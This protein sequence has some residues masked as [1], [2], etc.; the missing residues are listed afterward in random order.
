MSMVCPVCGGKDLV[1]MLE[2]PGVP[3]FCNIQLETQE[4]ALSQPTGDMHL[5]YCS[6]CAHIFNSAFDEALLDYSDAYENSLHYSATFSRF[7]EEL[8]ERLVQQF[9][10]YGKKILDIGCGKGDFLSLVCELG[11]NEGYGFDKS[12]EEG[13]AKVPEKG[14][15]Q[16]FNDF[17]SE[18]YAD[19]RPNMVICRH[20]LE[21]IPEP[22]LFLKEALSAVGQKS[23][24][25]VYFEVPNVLFTIRDL[26]VWDIIYEHCQYFS[27]QSLRRAFMEQGVQIQQV[28][29]CFGGQFLALEGCLPLAAGTSSNE[30]VISS[31]TLV[32]NLASQF[33]KKFWSVLDRWQR[34]LSVLG[35]SA[36]VWGAGSKGTTFLNLLEGSDQI[37][38]IIDINPNKQGKFTPCTGHEI[39][40]PDSLRHIQPNHVFVM[41]PMYRK[42]IEATMQALGT[43]AVIHVVE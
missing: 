37:A 34:E 20:V 4:E 17:F 14:S 28:Y 7:A 3:V 39:L 38:G 33:E 30:D 36:V 19:L 23:D 32:A 13:R 2:I 22:N 12:Y 41:N 18:K 29:E 5:E 1:K 24:C 25:T 26:G 27:P 10:L 21:H 8:A 16:Y 42:E 31:H 6:S 9:S 43:N 15:T 40:A 11:A 35:G